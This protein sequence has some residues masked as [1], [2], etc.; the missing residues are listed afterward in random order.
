MTLRGF[1]I[2]LVT[3][4]GLGDGDRASGLDLAG[5]RIAASELARDVARLPVVQDCRSVGVLVVV[6][7]REALQPCAAGPIGLE[8]GPNAAALISAVSEP[9]AERDAR[10]VGFLAHRKLETRG[11]SLEIGGSNPACHR[12]MPERPV[13]C[14]CPEHGRAAGRSAEQKYRGNIL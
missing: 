1:Q 14:L 11:A 4:S 5:R 3:G 2:A 12:R 13:S 6:G 9:D 8:D 10:G 7:E